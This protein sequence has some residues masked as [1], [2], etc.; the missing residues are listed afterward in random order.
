MGISSPSSS[1]VKLM[2]VNLQWCLMKAGRVMIKPHRH[3][4][5][6]LKKSFAFNPGRTRWHN[7]S[8]IG[9]GLTGT[10]VSRQNEEVKYQQREVE[11]TDNGAVSASKGQQMSNDGDWLYLS[12]LRLCSIRGV[13]LETW[14]V[15]S[16]RRKGEYVVDA[17]RRRKRQM[18]RIRSTQHRERRDT[19]DKLVN[20][21]ASTHTKGGSLEAGEAIYDKITDPRG[22]MVRLS[23]PHAKTPGSGRVGGVAADSEVSLVHMTLPGCAVRVPVGCASDV[24]QKER[25]YDMN[26]VGCVLPRC[27]ARACTWGRWTCTW[28]WQPCARMGLAGVRMEVAVGRVGLADVRAW[29]TTCAWADVHMGLVDGTT[30]DSAGSKGSKEKERV[31]KRQAAW[32]QRAASGGL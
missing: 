5:N 16:W 3:W 14:D 24:M 4:V 28:S 2:T 12:L 19:D 18:G 6:K 20:S 10:I 21:N 29:L 31:T 23:V 22:D 32:G 9:N 7:C 30:H 13:V 8:V 27:R 17:E 1:F 11:V 15:G 25:E 26:V